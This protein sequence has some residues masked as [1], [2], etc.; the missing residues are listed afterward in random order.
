MATRYPNESENN[1]VDK[2]AGVYDVSNA[3]RD[4]KGVD[5]AKV[6]TMRQDLATGGVQAIKHH[7]GGQA[8]DTPEFAEAMRQRNAASKKREQ[9][10]QAAAATHAST[11]A[12]KTPQTNASRAQTKTTSTQPT[13]A[14][15]I[16]TA[17]YNRK[18]A[19][20]Q[21]QPSLSR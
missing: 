11:Q 19:K 13:A 3:K 1:A 4:T 5:A 10:R 7:H 9:I 14:Q 18:V 8:T 16:R 17:E 12:R 21:S 6:R 2:D 15:R 20:T